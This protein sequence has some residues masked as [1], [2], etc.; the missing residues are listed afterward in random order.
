MIS[1]VLLLSLKVNAVQ[2]EVTLRDA[3]TSALEKTETV[4]IGTARA[5]QADARVNQARAKFFPNLSLVAGTQKQDYVTQQTSSVLG[6]STSYARLSLTQSIYEG[7]RDAATLEANKAAKVAGLKNLSVDKYNLF[8]SVAQSFYGVLS[9]DREVEN[10]KVT[11]KL[12]QDRVKEIRNRTQIGRSRNIELMAA[13]AQVAVL[14]AQLMAAEGQLITAWDQFV[15]LTGLARDVQLIKRRE[16]PEPPKD[17]SYY[18]DML[19]KRPDI[20]SMKAQV[21]VAKSTEDVASAG[22]F[23]SIGVT[24]NYYV[25]RDGPQRDNHWDVTG[26]LTFPIFSGGLIKAQVTEAKERIRE[27]EFSLGQ[28]R[29]RAEMSIRTAHNS[30]VAALN[31]VMSLESALKSTEQNYK[32][33]EKNYRFGQATNLDVIQALNSFQ[34]TKRTLDRTRYIALSAWADLRAATAQISL[35]DVKGDL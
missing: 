29:R 17:I 20:Q 25:T 24:G 21:Q 16:V 5:N 13:E 15:L 6:N 27:Y 14:Q 9:N 35:A 34:D 22:H 8:S 12:A 7:G 18:I 23:P 1:L 11:I 30:L 2:T 32:E 26:T 33:Q 28:T 19:D 3:F 10:L 4:G 31:Q